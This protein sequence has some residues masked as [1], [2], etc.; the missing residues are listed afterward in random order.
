[1][2]GRPLH[3]ARRFFEVIF[4]RPLDAS[5]LS[6]VASWVGPELFELFVSQQT[7]D[8]RHGYAT[9]RRVLGRG[10]TDTDIIAAGA[11]HDVGKRESRLGAVGRTLATLLMAAGLPMPRRM[12]GYR[13]HGALGAEIL[14]KAGAPG[15]VVRFARHHQGARPGSIPVDVWEILHDADLAAKPRRGDDRGITSTTE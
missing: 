5:E 1:M 6:T 12:A 13:D 2:P 8:Q 11:L 7:A 15:V 9:G 14:E 10:V 4:A 3:L